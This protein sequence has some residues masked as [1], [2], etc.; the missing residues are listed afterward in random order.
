M[1]YEDFIKKLRETLDDTGGDAAAI[2]KKLG[3]LHNETAESV[4]GSFQKMLFDLQRVMMEHDK[5]APGLSCL[6]Q[7]KIASMVNDQEKF[8]MPMDIN[9]LS[10][11]EGPGETE[12]GK[13]YA[14]FVCAAMNY[15]LAHMQIEGICR[16]VAG[17]TRQ[18]EWDGGPET[19][20]AILE[21]YDGV[22][23]LSDIIKSIDDHFT[24]MGKLVVV[25]NALRDRMI[26]RQAC[27]PED[28]QEGG[29]D[30]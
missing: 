14:Y 27:P 6:I 1:N 8:V 11:V 25:M 4:L 29:E 21:S 9:G 24:P 30:A 16:K 3:L 28:E 19:P 23:M 7:H 2:N 18:S 22:G 5:F 15:V 17:F 10:T 26:E 12:Q 20:E 13:A